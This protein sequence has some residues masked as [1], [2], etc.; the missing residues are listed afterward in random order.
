[1]RN[2]DA[3]RS[4]GA[5]LNCYYCGRVIADGNWFARVKFGGGQ[6][7]LCR[8]GCVELFLEHPDRCV[9]DESQRPPVSALDPGT[10]FKRPAYAERDRVVVGSS[11]VCAQ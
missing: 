1:M 10:N 9:G 8:P 11:A 3:T 4:D 2:F 7:V 5:P 6:V